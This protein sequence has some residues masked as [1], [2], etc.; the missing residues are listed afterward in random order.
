MEETA[1]KIGIRASVHAVTEFA[2]MG[3]DLLPGASAARLLE[4]IRGH[5]SLQSVE[6][7]GVVNE[8]PVRYTV[9]GERIALTV[10]GRID[11]LHG[12]S[13][14]EEIKTLYGNAP[15]E[16]DRLHRAQAEC[17]GFMVCEQEKL[18]FI[19]ITVTYLSLS[20]G[21]LTHFTQTL[22][23]DELKERFLSYVLPY[24]HYA[25]KLSDH[26]LRLAAELKALSF[27]YGSYRAGQK[28]L[29]T[30][31]YLSVRDKKTLLAQAPT[32]TGKTMA[33]LFPTLK[34][35]GETH[36][37]RIFY[38][39]ART[40]AGQAAFDAVRKLPLQNLRVVSI[41][42]KDKCC[43]YETPTCRT[44]LCPRQMGYY[45]RLP[46]ALEAAE[47]Q[48]G[49]FMREA[50]RKLAD[51]FL[52]CPF[53]LSLDLSLLCDMIVC[54]YN[55][56]FDPRVRLQRYLTGGKRGQVLLI[57][58]AHNLPSRAR[59]MYSAHLSTKDID[60][61]RRLVPKERRKGSAAYRILSE[62]KKRMVALVQ[63]SD[64]PRAEKEL[65]DE[66][67]SLC[68]GA[69][70]ALRENADIPFEASGELSLDLASFLYHGERY[71]DNDFL[72]YEGG[73]TFA[74]ITLFC[75]DAA[76]K[77]AAVLK[78]S[79]SVILFS[80][81]L[82]PMEFYRK[83]IGAGDQAKCVYLLS[84]FPQ[85]HLKVL[86]M[87]VSTRYTVREQTLPKVISAILSFVKSKEKGNFMVFFPSFA[88][89]EK[90][91]EAIELAGETITLLPQ[92]Q[93]MSE[94][95]RAEYLSRFEEHPEETLLGLCVLGSVF[96]EGVD[97]PGGR[98]SGAVIVGVGMPQIGMERETLK[99][100]AEEQYG[101]GSLY[102]YVY[103]G[104]GKVL[105][106]AGR[107]IRSEEDFG[108]ILLLDDRYTREPYV[109]LLPKEWAVERVWNEKEITQKLRA[110]WQ[111]NEQ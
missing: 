87:S 51:D 50:V 21:E 53:E 101:D 58:E 77:T 74:D 90:A 94:G 16:V 24:L 104:I 68:E 70:C 59:E 18:P 111:E 55:Y 1:Q 63:E 5:Q 60:H 44:G 27:P 67:L 95:E 23:R 78:K 106:A 92:R 100:R 8:V 93:N 17:Y 12:L 10:H 37:E 61:I 75:A 73:K 96:A 14:V 26:K 40:T 66:L 49:L 99:R 69:L 2:L 98:L 109:S 42:A 19:D 33:A 15:V 4:G 65:K 76:D 83:T 47:H 54:D 9:E 107:V 31:V 43:I 46:D 80:A 56:I 39:T 3:G 85:E 110:F 82:T 71:D 35:M 102:A 11:R 32:G 7:E 29:A 84:P 38:L 20:D 57:D 28:E 91:R 52:L 108:A 36:A 22:T 79:R 97:L 41:V 89:M 64:L 13:A 105:Q 34:A 88:Y 81:T 30:E 45:D 86:Q 6:Q 103:P 25:E 48:N 72:L 62:T